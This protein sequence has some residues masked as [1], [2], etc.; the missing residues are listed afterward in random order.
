MLGNQCRLIVAAPPKSGPVQRHGNEQRALWNGMQM[1]TEHSRN[2]TRK[3]DLAAMFEFQGN[4]AADV[5]IGNRCLDP[6]MTRRSGKTGGALRCTFAFKGQRQ[7]TSRA[8]RLREEM[9]LL[10]AGATKLVLIRGDYPAARAARRQGKI[11]K[12]FDRNRNCLHL[13][14]VDHIRARHKRDMHA[15]PPEI[16]DYRRRRALRERAEH[17]CQDGHFLWDML[18][19]D[20]ADRLACTTRSF[21]SCLFIGPLAD[22]AEQ[23]LAGKATEIAALPFAEED[24]LGLDTPRFDLVVSAGTLDSVNDLPGALVQIRRALRPDGLFLGAMFGAGSLASLKRAMMLADGERPSPHIHPQVELRA[25]A[26]LLARAGFTLPVADRVGANVRYANW[27]TLVCDLRDAGVGNC[28]AGP[29]GFLGRDY[30]QRVDQSW[31]A[32]ADMDGKVNERFEFLHLSGWSPSP[33]QP[34]PAVRGSGTVSLAT[35]LDKSG[36]L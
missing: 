27:R 10:P 12:D 17:R 35:I 1:P 9:Q 6:R 20:I 16:F 28:L 7:I 23:I 8:G 22:R 36:K 15:A 26:D 34:K 18:A 3:P 32:L 4:L 25:G 14:L 19:E 13:A 21:D 29:R 33:T 5:A 24:R 11:D 30:A 2:Q 31:S